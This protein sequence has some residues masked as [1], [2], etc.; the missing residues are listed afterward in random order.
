MAFPINGIL[1][2]FDRANADPASGT[3]T[4]PVT[5]F[6]GLNGALAIQGNQ[7]GFRAGVAF[8]NAQQY[9]PDCEA[10][11]TMATLPATG[12]GPTYVFARLTGLG[13]SADGYSAD[14]RITGGVPTTRIMRFL[15]GSGTEL[16]SR[17]DIT[18]ANGDSIGIEV[19]GST[20]KLYRKNGGAWTELLST[21]DTTY[22]NPGYLGVGMQDANCV[23][24]DFGGGTIATVGPGDDPPIGTL[25]RGAGW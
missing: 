9:G 4:T 6:A 11:I 17:T 8:W 14:F 13:S 1:D 3:W 10:Y 24:D 19:I 20:I 12:Q 18:W 2:N 22:P 16:T 5:G 23:L 25:G 15:D 21:T 7:L